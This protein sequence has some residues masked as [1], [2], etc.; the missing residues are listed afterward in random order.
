MDIINTGRDLEGQV[1]K[2]KKKNKDTR[3]KDKGLYIPQMTNTW[4]DMGKGFE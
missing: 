2:E 1:K 4:I 3:K